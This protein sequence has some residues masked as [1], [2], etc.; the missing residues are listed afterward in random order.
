MGWGQ[1]AEDVGAKFFTGD[2][3]VGGALSL[4]HA[5]YGPFRK[6]RRLVRY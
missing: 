3:A 6:M 1:G 2:D 4:F 5:V